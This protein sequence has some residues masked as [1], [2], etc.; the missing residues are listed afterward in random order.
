[1]LK[2]YAPGYQRLGLC[3]QSRSPLFGVEN[4]TQEEE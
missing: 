3:G 4:V 1:M 2:L